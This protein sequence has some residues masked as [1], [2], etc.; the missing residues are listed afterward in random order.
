MS[1]TGELRE[2]W[3]GGVEA[4]ECDEMAHMNVR[5]W[6][7][8][9]FDGL[10]VMAR[11]LGC[12]H[13]FTHEA[14]G[15]LA[16][17]D[18][19]IHFLR[20]APAGMPLFL[21]A[22]VLETRE[23]GLTIYSEIVQSVTGQ[24]AATFITRLEHVVAK[25]GRPF[26]LSRRMREAAEALTVDLPAHGRPRSIAADAPLPDATRDWAVRAGFTR[27]G[28]SAVRADELD[29]FGRLRA[30]TF[31]GRVSQAVPNLLAAWRAGVAEEAASGDGVSRRAGAAV[32]EYRLSFRAWPRM[33]DVIEV[34][35]GAVRVA[36]KTH[37]LQHWLV[38][39]ATGAPWCVAEAVAITFDLD[40]RKAIATPPRARAAL[41]AMIVDLS[42]PPSPSPP[43]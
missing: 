9:A 24:V 37:A 17:V 23:T 28:L 14:G 15:T 13:A 5:H 6:V 41:E 36:D 31:I 16:P 8:R 27:V 3:R 22:G 30:E 19:H 10:A 7:A 39:P 42:D 20:E 4:W 11:D 18:Q 1:A 2:Y 32:L 33:G 34:W 21:R 43:A 40:A 25:S 38:D 29:G 35:S 26:A 12:P